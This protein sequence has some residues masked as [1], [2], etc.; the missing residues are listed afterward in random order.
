MKES[1]NFYLFSKWL[2]T[3]IY[4]TSFCS[5]MYIGKYVSMFSNH[6]TPKS[7]LIN[8]IIAL[9]HHK[10]YIRRLIVYS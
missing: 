7:F 4:I 8:K 1:Y 9:V 5:T 10:L 2:S 3:N 6:L